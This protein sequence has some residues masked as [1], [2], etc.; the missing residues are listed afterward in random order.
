MY[1]RNNELYRARKWSIGEW[2]LSQD[3]ERMH[4]ISDKEKHLLPSLP[5]S[6]PSP[7]FSDMIMYSPGWSSAHWGWASDPSS[8]TSSTSAGH[9][10][11]WLPPQPRPKVLVTIIVIITFIYWQGGCV[12]QHKRGDQRTDLPSSILSL[13]CVHPRAWIQLIRLSSKHLYSINHL[14]FPN[15]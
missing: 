13:H 15:I 2:R 7:S 10:E 14:T 9:R 1:P 6:A 8:S 11:C 12:P 4:R 3:W 5:P